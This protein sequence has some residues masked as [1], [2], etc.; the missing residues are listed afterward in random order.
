M[1]RL[2]LLQ[3]VG[4]VLAG[5]CGQTCYYRPGATLSEAKRD[6]Q[7]CMYEGMKA[8][9]SQYDSFAAA[10]NKAQIVDQCMKLKG[11]GLYRADASMRNSGKL[12]WAT[13][14]GYPHATYQVAGRP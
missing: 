3:L 7:K 8:T 11:Y 1:K 13:V 4:L 10:W 12:A 9:A 5:G 14:G 2:F 6:C